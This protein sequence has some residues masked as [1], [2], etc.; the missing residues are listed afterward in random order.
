VTPLGAV[1]LVIVVLCAAGG[2]WVLR[3]VSKHRDGE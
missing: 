2:W 1:L 3:D